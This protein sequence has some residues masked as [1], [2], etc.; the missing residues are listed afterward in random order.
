M[1]WGQGEVDITSTRPTQPLCEASAPFVWAGPA[2]D[3][4][5]IWVG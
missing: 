2:L 4:L 3:L 5:G 1:T